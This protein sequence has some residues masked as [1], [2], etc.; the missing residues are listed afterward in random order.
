MLEADTRAQLEAATR[1]PE[2]AL[3]HAVAQASALAPAVVALL[4]KAADGVYLLPQQD[5]LLFYGLHA[6][7]AARRT[8]LFQPLMRLLRRPP[9]ELERR[10]GH[11]TTQTVPRLVLAVFD[12]AGH[13]LRLRAF[14]RA[15]GRDDPHTGP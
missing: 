3:R 10:L 1:P 9:Y 5:R 6:L 11:A 7:A 15:I 2:Q 13:D 14:D 8:E 12:N 4:N